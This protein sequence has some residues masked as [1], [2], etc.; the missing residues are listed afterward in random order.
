MFLSFAGNSFAELENSNNSVTVIPAEGSVQCKTYASNSQILSASTS[1]T[2]ATDTLNGPNAATFTYELAGSNPQIMEFTASTTVDFVI[3]K[4]ANEV[5]VFYYASGGVTEDGNLKLASGKPIKAISFCYGLSNG[6][7]PPAISELPNCNVAGG[8]DSTTI[9]CPTNGSRAFV[10][11]F[12][13][14]KK[15]F[16]LNDENCCVCNY[17]DVKPCNPNLEVGEEGACPKEYEELTEVPS[18]I[19][20]VKNPGTFYCLTLGGRRTCYSD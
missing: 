9:I 17:G 5:N 2:S 15:F 8:I 1:N 13:P 14:D 4:N 10:C 12:E 6:N 7:N 3:L 19:E 18:L 16:G 20:A 11:N